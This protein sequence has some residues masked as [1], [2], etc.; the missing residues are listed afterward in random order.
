MCSNSRFTARPPRVHV[1]NTAQYGSSPPP[2]PALDGAELSRERLH[3]SPFSF[4]LPFRR[5]GSM[6]IRII[7]ECRWMGL[8]LVW[9]KEKEWSF[10]EFDVRSDVDVDGL[11]FIWKK[12]G[13]NIII[14][15]YEEE[16]KGNFSRSK[17][18]IK[19][20]GIENCE[21]GKRSREPVQM[22]FIRETFPTF[23]ELIAFFQ[24]L[25]SWRDCL[26][27]EGFCVR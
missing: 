3:P 21:G 4:P 16:R 17:K 10:V 1:R 24:T 9:M 27:L 23:W 14:I 7:V 15:P 8:L 11:L 6:T 20:Y 18:T 5:L 2:L 25:I 13:R 26:L 19:N 22:K 12:E